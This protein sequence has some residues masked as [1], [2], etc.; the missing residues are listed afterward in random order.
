MNNSLRVLTEIAVEA[1]AAPLNGAVHDVVDDA[2]TDDDD[3]SLEVE[4]TIIP[5]FDEE[6]MINESAIEVSSFGAR[7][8]GIVIDGDNEKETA[9]ML[10][11]SSDGTAE[12]STPSEDDPSDDHPTT[13]SS[14][15]S[16]VEERSQEKNPW[17]L[18]YVGIPVNYFSVGIILGGSVSVLY[19]ILIIQHGVTSS[20]YSAA[21]SLVTLFWSYKILFGILCDCFPIRGQKWKPYIVLGWAMCA[22]MLVVLASMGKAV[23][24]TYLVIMLTFANLGYVAADVAADGYMVWMAHHEPPKR[25][26]KIQSL[27]YIVRSVGRVIMSI[28]IIFA[29]SGPAVSCPGYES[30]PDVPCTTDESVA[31][32]R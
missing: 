28:I 20:F 11:K 16:L 30:D 8:G 29:F 4:V 19:P 31:E 21:A 23:S 22:M 25:R 3:G 13:D 32:R 27:I 1:E 26:G 10:T 2:A 5:A 18:P 6:L 24:P 9:T 12:E 17:S 14:S 15:K 7:D